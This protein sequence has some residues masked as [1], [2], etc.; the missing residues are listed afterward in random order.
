[1]AE[2]VDRF[3]EPRRRASGKKGRGA[4]TILEDDPLLQQ[5]FPILQPD[6]LKVSLLP[7][8]AI[9]WEP[10]L[11]YMSLWGHLRSKYSI[12]SSLTA[13]GCWRNETRQDCG[14]TKQTTEW[15]D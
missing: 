10:S 7:N 3:T 4:D 1:M 15:E 6:L 12:Q 9:G 13:Q 2:K 5:Q 14:G 11:G 8:R